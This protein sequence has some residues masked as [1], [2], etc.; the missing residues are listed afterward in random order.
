MKFR[1]VQLTA[2]SSY[3][4]ENISFAVEYKKYFFS[5]WKQYYKSGWVCIDRPYSW[6][7]DLEKCQKL[8]STL[9]ERGTTHIKT[10]IGK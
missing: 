9:K 6:K 5:K 7:S 2:I 4:N 10:V 1:L 8:L 3:S